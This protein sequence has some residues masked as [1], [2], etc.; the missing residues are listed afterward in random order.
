MS[1]HTGHS[2]AFSIPLTTCLAEGHMGASTTC[3]LKVRWV[4]RTDDIGIDTDLS[5]TVGPTEA[6]KACVTYNESCQSDLSADN[7][8][9]LPLNNQA[10]KA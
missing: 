6:A 4:H 10:H 3:Q 2:N 5:D 1:R 9:K 7:G 8:A